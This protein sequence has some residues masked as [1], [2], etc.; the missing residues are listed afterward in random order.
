MYNII[1]QE[2]VEIEEFQFEYSPTEH[3]ADVLIKA[4]SKE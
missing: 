2:R 1:V 3:M 4:L